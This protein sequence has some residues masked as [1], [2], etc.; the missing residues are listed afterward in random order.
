MNGIM[1]QG[2]SSDSGKSFIAAGLC[3]MLSNMG[4]NICP[5]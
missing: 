4:M 2:T 5:F 1:I 3:R